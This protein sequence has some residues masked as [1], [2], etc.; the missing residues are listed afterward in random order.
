MANKGVLDL[1]P[2]SGDTGAVGT[3]QTAT[4]TGDY[5][6]VVV[7][8]NSRKTQLGRMT[9]AYT[10][11][12]KLK[13][14]TD[15]PNMQAAVDATH[16]IPSTAG[17]RLFLRLNNGYEIDRGLFVKNGDYSRY[18]I[19]WEGDSGD[20][21]ADTGPVLSSSFI[22]V[23]DTGYVG[24]NDTGNLIQGANCSMPVL[25]CKIN[26]NH[27]GDAGYYAVWN[28]NGF[29]YPQCGVINAGGTGI[30][31]RNSRVTAQSTR[32]HGARGAGMRAAHSADIAAQNAVLN[33]CMSANG[34][35]L[36]SGAGALDVSRRSNVHFRNG[37]ASNSGGAGMNV[38]R[39]STVCAEEAFFNNCRY[40]GVT[41]QQASTCSM[42]GSEIIDTL[43]DTGDTGESGHGLVVNSAAVVDARFCRITGSGA[44]IGGTED[45]FLGETGGLGGGA[46]LLAHEV[47][48]TGPGSSVDSTLAN[49]NVENVNIPTGRGILYFGTTSGPLFYIGSYDTGADTG[50][51]GT[52]FEPGHTLA[53]SRATTSAS[54]HQRFINPNGPVGSIRTMGATTR[55][56]TDSTGNV[57]VASGDGVPA[58][59]ANRGSI[60]LRRDGGT[61][62]TLYVKES[63]TD[64]G[65]WVAIATTAGALFAANADQAVSGGFIITPLDLGTISSGT[66]T[67]DPGDR[68]QQYYM[69]NGAHTLAPSSNKGS[70]T[71]DIINDTGSAGAI[72]TS[73]WTR[74]TGDPFTTTAVAKFRCWADIGQQGST[75]HAEQLA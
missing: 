70:Y 34:A 53:S 40:R 68:P 43:G 57:W 44:G 22:G 61:G 27:I 16:H 33:N 2:A 32:W 52:A 11:D 47:T 59:A 35:I 62:T 51:D 15:Y 73:G 46:T 5:M 1:P 41:V 66:V 24:N 9:K 67:P 12:T 60:Y 23:A 18:W 74:F 17:V 39:A 20:F 30:E 8:G 49:S 42:W 36:G 45:I 55:Y 48:T 4:D 31:V 10:V 6:H 21:G 56:C 75:L 64:T 50:K 65:G 54:L 29:V 38:R 3:I 28:C 25:A 26:A 14:P 7:S 13:I 19:T 58:T 72:T 63:A 37:Q 69:N 71:L